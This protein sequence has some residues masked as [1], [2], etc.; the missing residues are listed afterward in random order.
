MREASLDAIAQAAAAAKSIRALRAK[1]GCEGQ[2]A[3][4]PGVPCHCRRLTVTKNDHGGWN[5]LYPPVRS[6][7]ERGQATLKA[8]HREIADKCIGFRIVLVVEV[9]FAREVGMGNMALRT[10]MAFVAGWAHRSWLR[11]G[12]AR[13]FER[14]RPASYPRRPIWHYST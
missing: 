11:A 3:H 7:P 6:E 12:Q 5:G 8:G 9:L 4:K 1:T 10:V 14:T 2:R 13:N